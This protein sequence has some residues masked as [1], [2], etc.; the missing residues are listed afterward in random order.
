M[1]EQELKEIAEA[2]GYKLVKPVPWDCSCWCDYPNVLTRLKNG[3]WKCVD[4]MV[5]MEN[6]KGNRKTHCKRK[7]ETE[8]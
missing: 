5:L 1:T 3:K 4:R 2:M 6:R 7:E 8:E